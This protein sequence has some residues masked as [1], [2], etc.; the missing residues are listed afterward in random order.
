MV[1]LQ[2]DC[3]FPLEK[4][5]RS[6]IALPRSDT[7]TWHPSAYKWCDNSHGLTLGPSTVRSVWRRQIKYNPLNCVYLLKTA[8]GNKSNNFGWNPQEMFFK[9]EKK[10][11]CFKKILNLSTPFKPFRKYISVCSLNYFAPETYI[12]LSVPRQWL[13][14]IEW[15]ISDY[16]LTMELCLVLFSLSKWLLEHSRVINVCADIKGQKVVPVCKE[17]IKT[18]SVLPGEKVCRSLLPT[19]NVTKVWKGGLWLRVLPHHEAPVCDILLGL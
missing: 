14:F 11:H 18:V 7:L 4:Y 8:F 3:P 17:T 9:N 10:I 15:T 6:K 16:V 5:I 2:Q 1:F 12:W 19:A 13:I